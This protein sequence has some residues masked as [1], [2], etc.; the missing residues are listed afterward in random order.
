MPLPPVVE[1]VGA[2]VGRSVQAL[3]KMLMLV[4]WDGICAAGTV[5][6]RHVGAVASGERPNAKDLQALLAS[7]CSWHFAAVVAAGDAR[8]C[9]AATLAV[10]VTLHVGAREMMGLPSAMEAERMAAAMALAEV[11]NFMLT[12]L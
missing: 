9:G 1:G 8:T 2:T 6:S 3:S 11:V 7:H 5:N 10:G 12:G 4:P